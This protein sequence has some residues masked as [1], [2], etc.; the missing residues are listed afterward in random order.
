MHVGNLDWV[1]PL[2]LV[3]QRRRAVT[4]HT[5]LCDVWAKSRKGTLF[6]SMTTSGGVGKNK[7]NK[8]NKTKQVIR[9]R[10][11]ESTTLNFQRI[12]YQSEIFFEVLFLLFESVAPQRLFPILRYLGLGNVLK[13]TKNRRKIQI[14]RLI[15]KIWFNGRKVN[16]TP[17]AEI[18]TEWSVTRLCMTKMPQ[19]LQENATL[20]VIS[21]QKSQL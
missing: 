9:K 3:S 1:L 12:E 8:T 14:D 18:A 17:E 21:S 6:P 4:G 5:K 13:I 20:N 19:I 10:A 7:T 11:I 2:G 15:A 16:V